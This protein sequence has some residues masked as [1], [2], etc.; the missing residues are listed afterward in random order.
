MKGYKIILTADESL[1]S[2]YGG[3]LFL[4]FT[5]SGPIHNL[6][7]YKV[8]MHFILQP[9][10]KTPSGAAIQAPYS[11]RAIEASLIENGI[12]GEDEL[13]V[14]PPETLSKLIG[15][16]TRI[17]G[18]SA[19]DPKGLG[20]ASS[21]FS[22]PYGLIHSESYSAAKFKELLRNSAVRRARENGAAVVVGGYGA[23]Q[24]TVED[25]YKLGIDYILVGEGEVETPK[26]FRKILDGDAPKPPKIIY[27]EKIP[28]RLYRI[29]GATI[30][31]L[32]EISRGCGRGCYFC[33]ATLR[34]LRHRSIEDIVH[35]V[36]VNAEAGLDSVC[37]HAEDVLHYGGTPLEMK[38]EKVIKLFKSVLKVPGITFAGISH[39]SLASI[40]ENPKLVEEISEILG[41]TGKHWLG[42]QTGIETGSVRLMKKYMHMKPYP[43]KPEDW[44]QIVEEAFS[45]AYENHWIPAA[46]LLI[47]LPGEC[48]DDVIRTVE[49]VERLKPYKSLIVPLLYV[50]IR[51]SSTPKM[52]L[53]E[54][55]EWYHWELYK[56]IWE[57][58]MRWIKILTDEH[59][60]YANRIVR[61]T[62]GRFVNFIV[63]FADRFMVRRSL[64]KN[65]ENALKSR[66]LTVKRHRK[67]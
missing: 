41:L 46:T 11:L 42:F 37:L 32:V 40:V 15:E 35:D 18:I 45:T 29:R 1:M 31:G 23:W 64:K 25:M 54:D 9:V 21:T 58:D 62:V 4:G 49:L 27:S 36:K 22:G 26:L 24:L 50:P 10:P 53:L 60:K 52:R 47:N 56:A 61:F 55:A 34:R 48:E 20:P 2:N 51:D 65:L 66:V 28:D 17:I 33:T 7:F 19:M 12:V 16:E 3:S 43:F 5:T 57:H 13:I 6:P 38:P 44:P 8:L 63:N 30:G 67:L 59:L 14:A 39:A